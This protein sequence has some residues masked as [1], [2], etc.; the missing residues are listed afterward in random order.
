MKAIITIGSVLF[1]WSACRS[2]SSEISLDSATPGEPSFVMSDNLMG[3]LVKSSSRDEVGDK[4]TFVGLKSNKPKVVFEN[5]GTSP[6]QKVFESESTLTVILV[7]SGSG[8]IDA[9]VIDKKTGKFSRVTA[10]NVDGVYA[11]AAVGTIK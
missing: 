7:A 3:T 6:L 9:F 2:P 11:S 4:V 8:S 10:G 1:L 5:G